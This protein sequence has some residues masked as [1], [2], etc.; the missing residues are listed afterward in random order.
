MAIGIGLNTGPCNVGNMGSEQ[1]FD[2]SALGD[3]VN[4]A[5]RLQDQCKVYGV[6]V[7]LAETTQAAVRD[8]ATVE[9]D[10]VRVKGKTRPSRIYALVGGPEVAATDDFAAL[11]REQRAMLTAYRRQDWDGAVRALERCRRSSVWAGVCEL[12]AQRIDALRADTPGADW[13]GVYAGA[14]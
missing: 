4:L 8:F 11:R 7:I 1:R 13:D 10:L 2:Y 5:S 12:F 3:N 14:R 9:L 6:D